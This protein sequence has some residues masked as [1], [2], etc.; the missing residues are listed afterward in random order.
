M[1]PQM[2]LI[3]LLLIACPL[4][5]ETRS[6]EPQINS[7]DSV[8][9]DDTFTIGVTGLKSG[10]VYTLRTELYSGSGTIWR[11]EAQ[12]RANADGAFDIAKDVP[13]SGPWTDTDVLGP[14]WALQNTK[15]KTNDSSLYDNA[16]Y[17][18][19]IFQVREGDR[20]L[21]QKLVLLR[22][23]QIGVSTVEVRNDA[24][25]GTYYS[26]SLLTR[27]VPG[28]I[29]LSGSE[30]GVSRAEAS[31]IASHGYRTLAL[32]YFGFDKL[33]AELERIPVETVDR[34]VAWL[35]TQP[36]VDPNHI[37]VMGGSKGAELALLSA[38][39]N[40]QIAG[41]I[42][43]APSSVVYEG[44]GSSTNLV[45][46]WT[47]K[48]IEVPFAPYVHNETYAKSHRLIDLYDPTYD[49]APTNSR[50]AVE[51]ISGPILLLSGR[52]D[53]LWPSARMATRIKTIGFKFEFTNL[54]FDDVGHA[55]AHI[56]LRPTTDSVRLGGS[57]RSIA[58]ANV[59]SWR[60][61]IS[62]L[63]KLKK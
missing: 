48:G 17:T 41:V 21:A 11:S 36:G 7:P 52:S 33:P 61:I 22:N 16:D 49:A 43:Y 26:S 29:V 23:R 10:T 58:H 40:P 34:A 46:S 47:T 20:S 59:E 32:G 19:V 31:L 39:L 3:A 8:V 30:G 4:F 50:I 6:T 25:S 5:S 13:I 9:H 60:A 2:A 63:V 38:S 45:S 37:V 44:I 56:P 27:R 55:V 35:S 24:V 54:Q 14:F 57:A 15:E 51:K 53:E 62:F 42:A 18:P 12:F 28:V 1:R